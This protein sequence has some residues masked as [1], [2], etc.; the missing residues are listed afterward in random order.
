MIEL[1][2]LEGGNVT[3]LKLVGAYDLREILDFIKTKYSELDQAVVWDLSEGDISKMTTGDMRQ[4]A[5][6][7]AE[8]AKHKKTAFVGP[9]GLTF[10]LLR[11]YT[12]YAEIH[13]VP[14]Q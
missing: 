1:I 2:L 12:A 10:G 4:I 14:R 11:M 7:C 5:I 13:R 8:C 3:Q 6:S 9:D